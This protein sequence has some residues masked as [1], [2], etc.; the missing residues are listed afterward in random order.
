MNKLY[1]S[2]VA[3]A[4]AGGSAVAQQGS[5]GSAKLSKV[6]TA[7]DNMRGNQG[8]QQTSI[9]GA[10]EAFYS[11]D[12]S[13]GSIPAGWTNQDDLT[14]ET[15]TPVTF[16]WS[17]DPDAVAAAALNYQPSSTFLAPGASNGYLWANSDRGL[18]SAP[19]TNHLTRLTTG[20]IDCSG[21]STVMLTMKS[22]IGVFDIDA[23]TAVKVRVSTDLSSWTD[24]APFPCLQTGAAAPPCIR[25]SAN[26]QNIAIDITSVA[27]NQ[28]NVFI[29]FQWRGGWEYFWA[30]DDLELS[31]LPDNELVMNYAYVS[32]TGT[33]EEFGRT[34]LA[35]WNETLNVGAE[36]MNF[37][38]ATQTNLEVEVIVENESGTEVASVTTAAG[39]LVPTDTVLTDEDVTLSS[40][41]V[42]I[43]TATAT[44]TSDQSADDATPENNVRE[45]KF[46]VTNDLYSI[47]GIGVY[48]EDILSTTQVGTGS[49]L[50]NTENVRLLNLYI[51]REEAEATAVQIVL[52]PNTTAGSFLSVS[53]HDTTDVFANILDAPLAESDFYTITD[54]DVD[55]GVVTI[56]FLSPYMMSPTAYFVSA[57][58]Y[59]D[60]T[61]DL[62]IL[63]DVTVP[64]PNVASM[65]WIPN[66]DQNLYGGNG[67]A[68]AVRLSFDPS[69]G[70]REMPALEGV[71]MYPNPTN[72]ILRINTTKPEQVSVEVLNVLGEVVKT[73]TFVGNTVLDLA[74]NSAGVYSVR[75][76][77]GTRSMVQRVVL[78]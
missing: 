65:L 24:F 9:G 7:A 18:A 50:D 23:D 44:V 52:G 34:P 60:G 46:A 5:I 53:I 77:N 72:G 41:A 68:W 36:V 59:S 54:D 17:N 11:Q 42:G 27:A 37:G 4:L 6:H 25:W 76:S 75:V 69:I 12:F 55:A 56:P 14:P 40:V 57:N 32:Q 47:D 43:Y 78:N 8:L 74:G 30:I 28:E 26:P 16:E 22:L 70:V 29:Q 39:D 21:Q 38:G 71:S 73:S 31:P 64:Q 20:A 13:G 66:D 1:I 35:Q 45:R 67:T 49:F 3:F 62:F 19:P 51:I 15:G 10:R 33:G 48:P 2:A 63:D 58:T 61:N